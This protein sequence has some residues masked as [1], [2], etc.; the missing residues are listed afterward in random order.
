MPI[1]NI[2]ISFCL[3]FQF[4]LGNLYI[5]NDLSNIQKTN[6]L[7]S[8]KDDECGD[9]C[10]LRK[11]WKFTWCWCPG[12]PKNKYLIINFQDFF[13]LDNNK[14]VFPFQTVLSCQHQKDPLLD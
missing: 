14:M 7:N 12:K 1:L 2:I 11:F 9:G 4:S 13:I 3:M 5:I 6:Q 8:V 10:I